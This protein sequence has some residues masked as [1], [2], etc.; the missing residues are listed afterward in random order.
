MKYIQY[1][2][3]ELYHDYTGIVT[4][5]SSKY[6]Y[7][8]A[9]LAILLV[10]A[11]SII[12]L[13]NVIGR[14]QFEDEDRPSELM[15]GIYVNANDV[16]APG[17]ADS[18]PLPT[19]EIESLFMLWHE[20]GDWGY[21]KWLCKQRNKRPQHMIIKSMKDLGVWDELMESLPE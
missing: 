13:S 21:I 14:E 12:F 6:F 4:W 7:K 11:S 5:E 19:Q 8:D 20:D 18:E 10:N 3:E 1:K 9:G 2:L 15:T 16:F 17:D